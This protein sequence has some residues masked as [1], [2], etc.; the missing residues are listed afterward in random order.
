MATGDDAL[1]GGMTLVPGTGA[2]SDLDTYDNATRDYVAQGPQRWKPTVQKVSIAQGGTGAASASAARTALGVPA[3]SAVPA[4]SD[5][6]P[7][8]QV[9][10][11]QIARFGPTGK[12]QVTTP[13]ESFDVATKGYVDSKNSNFNGGTV[14]G[15]IYLPNATP[16]TSSYVVCYLNGDGRI[17]R[18]ASSARYKKYIRDAGDLGDLF[19][20]PLSEF[21]MRGGDG[22][23][24]VGYIAEALD[25]V[26]ALRRFVVYDDEG[27]P[28]SID[29]IQLLMA[30][31]TQLAARVRALEAG[32]DG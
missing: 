10:S 23:W 19:A 27:R 4:W 17:S 14:G 11:N 8:G 32:A 28:D 6:A 22:A 21:Q 15:D 16:A 18:G 2:A 13:T 30:Q 25:A 1:A 24:I 12:L 31:V 3:T 29:P 26:D 20:V 7:A 5:V 9:F